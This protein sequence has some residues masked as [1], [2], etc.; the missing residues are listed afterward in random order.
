MN[1]PADCFYCLPYVTLGLVL[2]IIMSR[3]TCRA[4]CNLA[5]PVRYFNSSKHILVNK[6]LISQLHFQKKVVVFLNCLKL[7][8]PRTKKE[9]QS[10]WSYDPETELLSSFKNSLPITLTVKHG[11]DSIMLWAHGCKNVCQALQ[12]Y[13]KLQCK[14][15]GSSFRLYRCWV[16]AVAPLSGCLSVCHFYN[17][18]P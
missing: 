16:G 7:I 8:F 6:I 2:C 15:S 10:L 1:N 17:P 9:T 12:L 5:K 18:P 4:K 11:G 14:T 13:V 3:I